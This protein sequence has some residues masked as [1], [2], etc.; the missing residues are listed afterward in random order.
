MFFEKKGKQ[1]M[2]P[3]QAAIPQI[4]RKSHVL[5]FIL[6]FFI[7]GLGFLYAGAGWGKA[8]LFFVIGAVLYSASYYLQSDHPTIAFVAWALGI[9][10]LIYRL[11]TLMRFISKRN[12][13]GL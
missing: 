9:I 13:G 8:I 6:E 3:Q 11:V 12:R 1:I 4:K 2:Y 5:G 10:F 7:G